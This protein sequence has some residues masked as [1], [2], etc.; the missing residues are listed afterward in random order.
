MNTII[1]NKQ[2]VSEYLLDKKNPLDDLIKVD[3]LRKNLDNE[4][5][6][7]E[8]DEINFTIKVKEQ[9]NSKIFTFPLTLF[10]FLDSEN[11]DVVT[12]ESENVNSEK[13]KKN[14]IQTFFTHD[15]KKLIIIWA[16]III[17]WILTNNFLNSNAQVLTTNKVIE[18]K[19]ETPKTNVQIL[20]EELNQN[21]LENALKKE[22]RKNLLNKL[23]K[24]NNE[25]KEIDNKNTLILQNI[26]LITK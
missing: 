14:I 23:E 5:L 22:E 15:N 10:D 19:Q 25:I 13:E 3:F 26:N 18:T 11:T 12:V 24:V 8:I 16:W 9:E 6:I 21:N 17:L 2:K 1:L 7:H 4:L 20:T